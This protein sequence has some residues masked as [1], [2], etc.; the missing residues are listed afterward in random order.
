MNDQMTTMRGSCHCGQITLA[1][2]TFKNP[3]DL[4]PRACDCSF[5]RKHGAAYISDPNGKLSI[6]FDHADALKRYQ[7]G[8]STAQFL[9]CHRC[10]VLMSVVFDHESRLYGAVNAAC[11]DGETGLGDA[12][13]ASPQ[14]LST[15]EKVSRWSTLWIPDVALITRALDG[16]L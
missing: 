1:F 8:S 7:Q 15:E 12:L 5:C 6:T 13:T 14:W 4:Q 10:G 16:H 9:M 2:S 11:L 3:S